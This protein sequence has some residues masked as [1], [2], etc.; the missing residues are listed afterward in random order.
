MFVKPLQNQWSKAARPRRVMGY[1][2]RT[3]RW[4]YTQWRDR[5]TR[6]I[7]AVELYNHK[8]DPGETVNV[9]ANAEVVEQLARQMKR[10]WRGALPKW[11][12]THGPRKDEPM[13]R[14]IAST[15]L[16]ALVVGCDHN[17]YEIVITPRGQQFTRE[18]TVSRLDR[19][20]DEKGNTQPQ[21]K[22][23]PAADMAQIA[24]IYSA[25]VPGDLSRPNVFEATFKSD[26]PADVGGSGSYTRFDTKMGSL[27]L[28]AERFRGNDDQA[29]VLEESFTAMDQIIDVFAGWIETQMGT[30]E[31]CDE[32]T[33]FLRGPFSRDLK[34]L[35]L[36]LW[37]GA[38]EPRVH[39]IEDKA[40]IEEVQKTLV[41]RAM[42]YLAD[43]NYFEPGEAPR[44][45][46]LFKDEI[47]IGQ[48]GGGDGTQA[49]KMVREFVENLL[50]RKAGIKSKEL[51]DA[52]L[53]PLKDADRAKDS[54]T[55]YFAETDHYKSALK[56]WRSRQ[57]P[58]G[59]GGAVA[60]DPSA[61]DLLQ[62]LLI[63][64][65]AGEI[66]NLGTDDVVTVKLDLPVAPMETNGLWDAKAKQ[67]T[68]RGQV[69]PKERDQPDRKLPIMCYAAWIEPNEAFQKAHFGETV[70]TGEALITYCLWRRSLTKAEAKRWDAF[71]AALK[72]GD[73]HK[74]K[75]AAFQLALG[76]A[77]KGSGQDYGKTVVELL[78]D[79]LK[80]DGK[81]D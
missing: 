6:E 17:E 69:S 76:Q 42:Q 10:G 27:T 7:V 16:L 71:V 9:S 70:V 41:V 61:D 35:N 43:R 34:N 79:A 45:F 59:A 51:V 36:M 4:R 50:D 63:S 64:A 32:L 22:Q 52:L 1:S 14:L 80:G 56:K 24:K 62:E 44:M 25:K 67:L 29:A 58:A 72:P 74:A 46:R 81:A 37:L 57:Q 26:M 12:V 13:K 3:D 8:T 20:T 31:C 53:A 23:F 65:I 49:D 21:Y 28:Y 38:N 18:L 60:K 54:L 33:A 48:A 66:L 19:V 15:V 78:T 30:V 11:P 5:K 68:W 77:G 2:M 55:A 40:D 47:T 39:R 75:I 73:D